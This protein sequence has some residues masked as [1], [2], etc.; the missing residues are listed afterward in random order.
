MYWWI[1]EIRAVSCVCRS[2][3]W[4]ETLLLETLLW[5]MWKREGRFPRTK[6]RTSN[7]NVRKRIKD[8]WRKTFLTVTSIVE[9]LLYWKLRSEQVGIES[10]K[11]E[12]KNRDRTHTQTNISRIE[13]FIHTT[14]P[15]NIRDMLLEH[16]SLKR[17]LT[18]IQIVIGYQDWNVEHSAHLFFYVSFT[19]QPIPF[20]SILNSRWMR[21]KR[22]SD[23]WLIY[24][25]FLYTEQKGDGNRKERKKKYSRKSVSVHFV[26][27]F[28]SI[29][30]WIRY[31][32]A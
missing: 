32:N 19:S 23:V 7:T 12:R 9:S 10:E 3:R 13:T 24:V 26:Q 5:R 2:E 28:S 25:Y 15:T 20:I 18:F 27:S 8:S 11:N 14:M 6:A 21:N 31:L 29:F 30:R 17:R 4:L 22:A 16:S 1:D